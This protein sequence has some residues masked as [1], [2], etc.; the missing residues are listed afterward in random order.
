MTV[1]QGGVSATPTTSV[2]VESPDLCANVTC[3]EPSACTG[4]VFSE[5]N[6]CQIWASGTR[7]VHYCD[8]GVCRSRTEACSCSRWVYGSQ[9]G[10]S[11]S[12]DHTGC[13]LCVSTCDFWGSCVPGEC[14]PTSACPI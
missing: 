2:T 14:R 5:N 8:Q 12:C 7:T 11:C 9:C 13:R 6:P 4:C 3:P 1:S 10:S